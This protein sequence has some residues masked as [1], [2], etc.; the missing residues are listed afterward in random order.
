[1]LLVLLS[2]ACFALL[3]GLLAWQG[4]RLAEGVWLACQSAAAA[5]GGLLPTLGLILPILVLTAGLIATLLSALW[6]L[7]NTHR[8]VRVV[9]GRVAPLPASIAELVDRHQLR[10]QVLLVNDVDAY[11]F[12][13]GLIRPRIWVSTALVELLDEDE[14]VSVL[15]HERHH[16]RQRDPLRVLVCRS[17]AHGL[18]FLPA[19]G[20]LHTSYLIAKETEADAASQ[21]RTALASALLKLLKH[22]GG[23]PAH[24]HVAAIGP[25]NVTALRIERLLERRSST[26]RSRLLRPH[27][28]IASLVVAAALVAV[29]SWS[30]ARAAAP[31]TG[32]ECGY[33][34]QLA[35]VE[36]PVTPADYTPAGAA[37]H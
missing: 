30:T 31:L 32:G 23:L 34:T 15:Q 29:S 25:L 28:V 22:G 26:R 17:L 19:A 14:L 27:H 1:L 37:L 36:Y 7:W 9:S 2:S 6:Q 33:T 8:L 11:A 18:F 10:H 4:H 21:G 12:A 35:P 16:L 5:V 24:A 20:A 3:G 13:Q